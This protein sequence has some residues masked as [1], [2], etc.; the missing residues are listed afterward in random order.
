VRLPAGATS[1]LRVM[2]DAMCVRYVEDN[3][4]FYLRDVVMFCHRAATIHR[5]HHPCSRRL[6]RACAHVSQ[7]HCVAD[8]VVQLCVAQDKIMVNMSRAKRRESVRSTCTDERNLVAR[9]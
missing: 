1:H 5:H 9:E 7:Q 8:V 3:V 2:R 4:L 6:V